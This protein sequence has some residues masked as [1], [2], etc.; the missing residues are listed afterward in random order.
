M[1]LHSKRTTN[2][3]S[4]ATL[5]LVSDNMGLKLFNV[6]EETIKNMLLNK[7]RDDSWRLWLYEVYADISILNKI[8]VQW[9]LSEYYDF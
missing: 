5:Q 8:L 7:L 4:S 3:S 2:R 1:T 9:L 6:S